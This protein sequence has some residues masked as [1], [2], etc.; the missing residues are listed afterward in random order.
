MNVYSGTQ[1]APQ[2]QRMPMA[3]GH[4]EPAR[5]T[6]THRC[7]IPRLERQT[8]TK[9]ECLNLNNTLRHDVHVLLI[10]MQEG[11]SEYDIDELLMGMA[12]QKCER[13]DMTITPDLKGAFRQTCTV[14]V[15]VYLFHTRPDDVALHVTLHVHVH[16]HTHTCTCTVCLAYIC[17]R[18]N[19]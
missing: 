15:H 1:V 4:C 6:G 17:V 19:L 12:S 3:I 14:H 8:A 16:V 11:V 10:H 13:E 5:R 2:V 9:Q 18:V 7:S